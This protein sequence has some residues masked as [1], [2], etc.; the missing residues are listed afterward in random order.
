MNSIKTREVQAS[1]VKYFLMDLFF[2]KGNVDFF[3][4]FVLCVP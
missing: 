1:I 2:N 3:I 4:F